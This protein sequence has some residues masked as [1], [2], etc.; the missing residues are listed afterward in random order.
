[1]GGETNT[2]WRKISRARAE[3][4]LP[5]M[6][7]AG[8]GEGGGITTRCWAEGGTVNP[9]LKWAVESR[10]GAEQWYEHEPHGD[11]RLIPAGNGG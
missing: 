1:M 6:K 5:G 7:L 11:V 4:L 8:V 10:S 3:L 2:G 9:W